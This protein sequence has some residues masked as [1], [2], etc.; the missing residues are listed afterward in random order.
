[1]A[2]QPTI[3]MSNVL[4][5]SSSNWDPLNSK[6]WDKEKASPDCVKRIKRLVNES[7]VALQLV[8]R[9]IYTTTFLMH[10]VF[11]SI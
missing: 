3:S 1:M 10:S 9:Q 5:A 11:F 6:D 7:P 4:I 2:E 8:K